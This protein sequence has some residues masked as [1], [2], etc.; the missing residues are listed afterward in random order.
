MESS[1]PGQISYTL[2][3]LTLPCTVGKFA[4]TDTFHDT[5]RSEPMPNPSLA[6][7]LAYLAGLLGAASVALMVA[8][9][10]GDIPIGLAMYAALGAVTATMIWLS[11]WVVNHVHAMQLQ[12][13]IM[14]A[15]QFEDAQ[16]GEIK[17]RTPSAR[18]MPVPVAVAIPVARPTSEGQTFQRRQTLSGIPAAFLGQIFRLAA[19][20]EKNRRDNP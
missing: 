4:M 14:L 12:Q 10:L 6:K 1:Q 9:I 18:S 3:G 19:E 15:R 5:G 13:A 11:M 7:K 8:Q 17:V 16:T 20:G 2:W